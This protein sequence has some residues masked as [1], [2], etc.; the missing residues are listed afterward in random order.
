MI[1][2]Y[3]TSYKTGNCKVKRLKEHNTQAKF[4]ILI[5]PLRCFLHSNAGQKISITLPVKF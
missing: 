3:K 2:Y 1:M 4:V 5:W